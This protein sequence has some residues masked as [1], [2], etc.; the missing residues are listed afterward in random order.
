LAGQAHLV[1]ELTPGGAAAIAAQP[2]EAL[3]GED[4]LLD[5]AAMELGT[6]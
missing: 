4:E 3:I 5:R 2:A 6:D 1:G